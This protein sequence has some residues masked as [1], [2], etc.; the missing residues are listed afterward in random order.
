MPLDEPM[1]TAHEQNPYAPAWKPWLIGCIVN[2]SM[3][4]HLLSNPVQ[5][6]G[7]SVEALLDS[8]STITLLWPSILPVAVGCYGTLKVTCVHAD[9]QEVVTTYIK[10]RDEGTEWK[11]SVGVIHNIPF[12]LLLG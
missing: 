4:P 6:K 7:R 5:V 1:P 11:L 3:S 9:T 8:G 12:S 10:I 2:S